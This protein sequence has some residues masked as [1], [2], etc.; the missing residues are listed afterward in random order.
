M[1]IIYYVRHAQSDHTVHDDLTRPLTEKGM[2]DRTLVSDYLED[3]GVSAVVSSPYQ[4]AHDTVAHFAQRKGLTVIHDDRLRERAITD[5]WIDDFT[6]FAERQWA[7]F[8][9]KLPGGESLDEVQRRNL[10]ALHELLRAY[11]GQAIAVGTHGTA[12]S[13]VVRRFDPSFTYESFRTVVGLMPWIVRLC[14]DGEIFVS[15]SSID[16]FAL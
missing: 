10:E 8:T 5:G 15:L 3:K 13:T 1:T 12:L 4:R 14:F 2:R 16:P 6:A 9:Y 11:P 7:D